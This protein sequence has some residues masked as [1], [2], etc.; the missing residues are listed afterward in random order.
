[1]G[2]VRSPNK[3]VAMQNRLTVLE[4]LSMAGGPLPEGNR[5]RV[6]LIRQY[7]GG[8]RVVYLD[9]T[10]RSLLESPYYFVRPNDVLH[11]TPLRVREWGTGITAQQS[12]GTVLTAISLLVNSILL[13]NTLRNL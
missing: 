5:R 8:S 7:P 12:M 2:E 3:F 10:D 6:Q 1:M 13:Y 11:V 9:L 4:A